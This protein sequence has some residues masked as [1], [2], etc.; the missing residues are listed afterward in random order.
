M[1]DADAA[2]KIAIVTQFAEVPAVPPLSAAPPPATSVSAASRLL[3]PRHIMASARAV[4]APPMLLMVL[5]LAVTAP[6]CRAWAGDLLTPAPTIGIGE[7]KLQQAQQA[8]TGATLPGAGLSTGPCECGLM[9][10]VAWV[11]E[12]NDHSSDDGAWWT[13]PT[14]PGH[15]QPVPRELV[16]HCS[17]CDTRD[18]P[19]LMC[20]HSANPPTVVAAR[21]IQ[22]G[23]QEKHSSLL[24]P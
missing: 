2:N 18:Y 14:L 17:P 4:C 6:E 9:M 8:Y 22:G 21:A 11:C 10:M 5:V 19:L 7:R 16:K 12:S 23:E 15:Q 3:G 1:L 20:F 13:A 24:I